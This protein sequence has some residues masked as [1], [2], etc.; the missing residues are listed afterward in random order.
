MRRSDKSPS[1]SHGVQGFD[2]V[3]VHAN[4]PY[5]LG[6]DN[7]VFAV[8]SVFQVWA[9]V[10]WTAIMYKVKDCA[11]DQWEFIF[12]LVYM[13]GSWFLINLIT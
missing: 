7:I 5:I 9:G 3:P 12:T 6:F 2:P 8:L 1:P 11:G 4:P 13:S 10:G